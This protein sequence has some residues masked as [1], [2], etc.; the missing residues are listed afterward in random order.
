MTQAA[1]DF[2]RVEERSTMFVPE[3]GCQLWVK[4]RGGGGYGK[5]W[6]GKREV[7]AHRASWEAANGQRVPDGLFVCHKCDTP[8]CVN[9]A[10]LFAGT[11]ADNTQDMVKKRRHG[12]VQK[13]ERIARG[14]RNGLRKAPWKA[15]R[16]VR[17]GGRV[18]CAFNDEQVRAI[19]ADSRMHHE[20]ASDYGVTKQTICKI[21][22][23][24]A[25]AH[26]D[27]TQPEP[28]DP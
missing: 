23:R 20:V 10:H 12:T 8:A 21:R 19:R 9:P 15:A 14:E 25:Y 27:C 2:R 3:S 13:P 6:S 4:K 11:A 24:Q 18:M 16:G 5:L 28:I 22:K 1:I 17:N 7:Q 26:V